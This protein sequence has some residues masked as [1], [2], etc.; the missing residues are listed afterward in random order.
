MA[1][2]TLTRY[3]GQPVRRGRKTLDQWIQ[4]CLLDEEQAGPCTAFVLEHM[5]GTSSQPVFSKRLGSQP[6]EPRALARLIRDRA[7]THCQ[8]M[9]GV[10]T[11]R[12]LAFYDNRPEH[13]AMLPFTVAG[14]QDYDGLM[15]EAPDAKGIV[16]QCM[17]HNEG[18]LQI[19][20][21]N[22]QA[23]QESTID[24]LRVVSNQNTKLV[25]ENHSLL[26]GLRD[27]LIGQQNIEHEHKMAE[28]AYQRSTAERR[29]W[30]SY[31]PALVNTIVGREVFPQS[32][33]DTALV[34]TFA[35]NLDE[36]QI[37]KLAEIV[38]PELWGPLSSRLGN[39][40]KAKRLAAEEES[41][42]LTAGDP[43]NGE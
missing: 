20:L 27:M 28:M 29:K 22:G 1:D 39:H 7:E 40:L 25:E 30:L 37:Q 21:R 38:P 23:L 19:A 8:D 3:E 6:E 13:G 33:A 9:P 31:G 35:D 24:M 14:K 12:L 18:V 41:R 11:F 17:R 10:Q 43:E 15:T 32:T 5:V 42:R 26:M 4:E 34:E 2:T 36:E 16:A